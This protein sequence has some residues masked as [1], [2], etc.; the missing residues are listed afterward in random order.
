MDL[1]INFLK[2]T[3]SG[4]TYVITVVISIFFILVIIGY[5]GDRQKRKL[6]DELKKARVNVNVKDGNRL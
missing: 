5:L 6:N 1:I 4:W 3:L 2:D